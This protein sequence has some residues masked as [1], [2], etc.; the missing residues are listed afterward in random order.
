[1]IDPQEIQRAWELYC[2]G[3][4]LVEVRDALAA[5]GSPRHSVNTISRD[6]RQAG[7]MLRRPGRRPKTARVP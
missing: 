2:N 6:M 3:S 4:T 5:D 1:M 7:H